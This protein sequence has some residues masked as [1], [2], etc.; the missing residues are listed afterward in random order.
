[1]EIENLMEIIQDC[2]NGYFYSHNNGYEIMYGKGH[3]WR[4]RVVNKGEWQVFD[5]KNCID[6]FNKNQ[7]DL[8]KFQQELYNTVLDKGVYFKRSLKK[9]ED[10]VGKDALKERIDS[11][12][13]FGEALKKAIETPTI[14]GSIKLVDNK[15]D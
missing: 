6:V 15:E 10:L 3:S 4:L 14:R 12:E 2:I 8:Y 11:W 5:I 1:M 9:I 7:I 13:A